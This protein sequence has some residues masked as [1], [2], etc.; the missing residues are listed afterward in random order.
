VLVGSSKQV[1]ATAPGVAAVTIN[2]QSVRTADG[3]GG[4]FS[5]PATVIP[6]TNTGQSA[7][8]LWPGPFTVHLP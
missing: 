3:C 4:G 5:F 8:A 2:A 7:Q 6:L 1:W